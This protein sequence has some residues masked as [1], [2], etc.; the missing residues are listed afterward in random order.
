MAT[1]SL[2]LVCDAITMRH[3]TV[4]PIRLLLAITAVDAWIFGFFLF[5]EKTML[6]RFPTDRSIDE[7]PACD[8]ETAWRYGQLI[9]EQ[10]MR[11]K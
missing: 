7:M 10:A 11:L 3:Y 2:L 6:F 5:I 8:L 4:F 1:L 9:T